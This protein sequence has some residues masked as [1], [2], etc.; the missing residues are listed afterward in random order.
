ML[1]SKSLSILSEAL[2]HLEQGFVNLP[3]LENNIDIDAL[4]K[5]MLAVADKMKDNYPY[6]HPFYAGQMLKPPHPIA[7]L[8]YM[9]AVWLNPNNHA[10]DGG[11]ASSEMEKEAVANI[12][13]MFGWDDFLGHLSSGG[14][15][16]NLE[17]LWVAGK[18]NPGKLVVASEQSHYT[19][20]R[21]SE[22]L[23][24]KYKAVPCDRK[25]RMNVDALEGLLKEGNVGTVV[26][27]LGTTGI[28]SIDP[29]PEILNLREKYDF[30]VHVDS[31]YGGY[32]TLIGN[33]NQHGRKAFDAIPEVDSIVVDPHK[34]GLQPYGCGCVL[35]K[36]PGVGRFYK[37][38]SP[39]TYFSSTELHLGEISLECS[40][41]GASAVAL[42]AT[43]QLL[44]MDKKGE[45]ALNL[46]KSRSAAL[47]LFKRLSNDA[48]FKMIVEPDLDIVIWVIKAKTASQISELS[49]KMFDLAAQKNLH[50]ALFNLPSELLDDSWQDI[51]MDEDSVVC[52]RS[53]LMK[54]EHLD[55]MD[56]IWNVL[57]EVAERALDK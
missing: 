12:A 28:G 37:H 23:G 38:D 54:P 36:D 20:H 10:L 50:L 33:L 51:E 35:F 24:L 26:V 43:Q 47:D 18:L 30:R 3:E 9:L 11:R 39:Y 57:D 46:E 2:G 7:R 21:I 29:L 4:R 55:W 8:A 34:H 41:A 56:Q 32:F 15:M 27:T 25:A 13:G 49:Q 19:H 48:R 45:F 53:C 22:V 52:L 40:R 16:A 31:A 5:V 42:W 17:A 6:F 1:E 44:P 14:T